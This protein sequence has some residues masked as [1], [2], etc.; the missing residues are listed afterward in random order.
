M[1]NLQSLFSTKSCANYESTVLFPT[2]SCAN[3]QSTVPAL[4]W[5]LRQSRIYSPCSQLSPVSM[6]MMNLQFLISTQ[7]CANDDP[8]S[9]FSTQSCAD[10]E[11]TISVLNSPLV[12]WIY[13][14]CLQLTLGND[15]FIQ[16]SHPSRPYTHP[17][18]PLPL[19][20]MLLTPGIVKLELATLRLADVFF[21][22]S[23]GVA[24]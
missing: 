16:F 9:L 20:S 17:Q 14:S 15:V 11:S 7:P 13:R 19:S 6:I 12:Q 3:H 1:L 24:Q 10:D 23:M 18:V 2:Q 8:Q 5:V 4:T 22:T 21:T